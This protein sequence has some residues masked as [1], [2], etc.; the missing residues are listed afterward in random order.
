MPCGIYDDAA[1]IAL[2]EEHINTI[3]K[4]MRKIEDLSQERKVNYN[5]LTRWV[6][7]KELHAQYIQDIVAQYFLTQR[8]KP[9]GRDDP[10]A[11]KK[12]TT[13]LNLLHQMLMYAMKA[14]QTTDTN[15]AQ[16]LRSLLGRFKSVYFN[17]PQDKGKFKIDI[18]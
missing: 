2:L 5:Q 13:E 10:V 6:N 9:A 12:Y 15:I 3:E 14:K 11:Y 7:N 1:G 4:S 17:V 8:I 18:H 16:R